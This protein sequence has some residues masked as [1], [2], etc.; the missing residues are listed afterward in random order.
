VNS[1]DAT[2]NQHRCRWHIAAVIIACVGF[3]NPVHAGGEIGTANSRE[4]AIQQATELMPEGSVITDTDCTLQS[5]SGLT[6]YACNVEC[7]P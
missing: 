6:I 1:H 5:G 2:L 3:F 4:A 7:E